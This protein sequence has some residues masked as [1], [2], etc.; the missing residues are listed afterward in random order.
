MIRH[1]AVRI[2]LDLFAW[3]VADDVML[4]RGRTEDVSAA[5]DV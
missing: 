5:A 2:V 3:N 1:A 4:D